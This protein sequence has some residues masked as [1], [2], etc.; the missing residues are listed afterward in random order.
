MPSDSSGLS[1]EKPCSKHDESDGSQE[2]EVSYLRPVVT[3][4]TETIILPYSWR[5]KE[6]LFCCHTTY[7]RE[8]LPQLSDQVVPVSSS[9]AY[10]AKRLDKPRWVAEFL[11]AA[12][13]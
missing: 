3:S 1:F 5:V 2:D 4:P 11:N 10:F 7:Y 13:S 9:I 8:R 12:W 6:R